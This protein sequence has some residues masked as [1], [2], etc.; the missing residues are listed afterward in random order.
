M[1]DAAT[2]YIR[3]IRNPQKRLYAEL[4]LAHLLG[5]PEPGRPPSLSLMA[6]QA[7]EIELRELVS[8]PKQLDAESKRERI[9]AHVRAALDELPVG[10]DLGDRSAVENSLSGQ[11][12]PSR[13]Y[14]SWASPAS[15][16][17]AVAAGLGAEASPAK[18]QLPPA[19]IELL[20][21]AFS[22]VHRIRVRDEEDRANKNRALE[23][24]QGIMF[25][26]CAT[27]GREMEDLYDEFAER[28]I[29][30]HESAI[31]EYPLAP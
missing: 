30:A 26:I 17:A 7:V 23:Y 3:R 8:P 24:R 15:L 19:A 25:A 9:L 27:T 4:Y 29:A 13:S 28:Q 16:L 10:A 5:G 20:D 31:A 18:P 12:C 21:N 1:N 6:A 2:K 11:G 22:R 14:G